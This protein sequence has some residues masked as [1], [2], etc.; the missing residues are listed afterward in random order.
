[1]KE[2]ILQNIDHPEQLE[3]LYRKDNSAFI[4]SF[5]QIYPD[6]KDNQNILRDLSW[7][8]IQVNC[9]IYF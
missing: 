8:Q 3:K 6:Y 2:E 1:M 7:L 4:K 5:N 9:I